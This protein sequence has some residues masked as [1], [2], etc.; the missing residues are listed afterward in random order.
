MPTKVFK[1]TSDTLAPRKQQ[2]QRFQQLVTMSTRK[3]QM[4]AAHEWYACAV[5]TVC[6]ATHQLPVERLFCFECEC[7]SVWQLLGIRTGCGPY[8]PRKNY[9]QSARSRILELQNSSEITTAPCAP[10]P[11]TRDQTNVETILPRIINRRV[12]FEPKATHSTLSAGKIFGRFRSGHLCI[13]V[14]LRR[15]HVC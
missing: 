8:D 10:L 9:F 2:S 6:Q 1:S 15:E 11:F 14:S 13:F 4:K 3:S 12:N 7:E 5:S